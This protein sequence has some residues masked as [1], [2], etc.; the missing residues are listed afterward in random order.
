MPSSYNNNLRLEMIATG[1]QS[2]TWGQT[3][4]TNLGT[5]I[6]DAITGRTTVTTGISPYTLTALNGTADESRAAALELNTSTGANYVVIVPTVTKLYVVENVNG[7]YSV[8]VKTA[9]G[10]GVVVPPTKSVLLRCDGTNVVE[11]LDQVVGNFGVGGNTTLTGNLAA[12][13]V[14]TIN[15]ATLG[16]VQTATISVASPTL[17]TVASAPPSGTAVLFSTTNTLPT[18]ITA[19]T[20]YYVSRVSSTTFN[21]S[22]SSTLTPLVDVSGAGS[23]THSVAAISQAVTA[24]LGTSSNALATTEFVLNNSNPTGGLMMWPTAAAPSGWLLC[25]GTAVSRTTYA[26]LFAVIGTTFG[27]GDNSTTFNLPNYVE[28]MP[29]GASLTTTASVTGCIGALVVGSISG[30]TMTV[31]GVTRGTLAVGDAITGTGVPSGSVVTAFGTGS[32]GVGTY[33]VSLGGATVTGSISGTTLTVTSVS[34]GTLAVGQTISGTGV[35]GGTTITAFGTGSGGTGTYSVSASQTVGSTTITA[36]VAS[37]SLTTTGTTMTVTAVGSGT[38]IVAQILTGT[39]ITANTRITALGTGT[40]ATGTY[41]VNTAQNTGLITITASPYVNIGSTGGSTDAIVVAHNHTITDPGH[42]HTTTL[43]VWRGSN[44]GNTS[45]AWGG[46]DRRDA[47]G[48]VGTSNSRV[49][50][51]SLA[52]A[53]SSGVNANMSPYLGI[54]FIIKT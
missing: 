51:I 42:T 38:L 31:S 1:E 15:S 43:D 48:V 2:G 44:G 20:T 21:I 12:N 4:N 41:I 28:R 39:G 14:S 45:A 33:T 52:S 11:Q 17:I 54:N 6:V 30:T 25:N 37:T 40:G 27:V 5:L 18:G 53:G 24:P 47:V 23:G 16:A 46:G 7:T 34:S 3:T 19:G 10:S 22:A 50:G 26:A 9:S 36:V 32:G 29:F 35:T 49:T 13:G 8:E